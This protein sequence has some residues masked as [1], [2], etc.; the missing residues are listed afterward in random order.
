MTGTA[1]R[2]FAR[3]QEDPGGHRETFVL[4]VP[5]L[6]SR[7]GN[8]KEELLRLHTWPRGR[9]RGPGVGPRAV[10]TGGGGWG[11]PVLVEP[12]RED[13]VTCPSLLSSDLY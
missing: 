2:R 8:R 11:T 7:V 4:G 1:P 12:P 6:L 3:I 5:P 9:G 10:G 13:V